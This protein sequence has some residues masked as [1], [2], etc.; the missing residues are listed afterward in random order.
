MKSS[1][2]YLERQD[3]ID[4][5]LQFSH[6]FKESLEQL[7]GDEQVLAEAFCT[8][9]TW[10]LRL[11]EATCLDPEIR[12]VL[13]TANLRMTIECMLLQRQKYERILA[14]LLPR[15]DMRVNPGD[16]QTGKTEPGKE[17]L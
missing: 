7:C 5:Q 14:D 9:G 8:R 17:D 2:E 12:S 16:G 11:L 10:I 3:W 4:A 6:K 13:R 1:D 15:P